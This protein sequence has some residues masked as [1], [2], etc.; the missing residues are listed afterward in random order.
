MEHDH[1]TY[2]MSFEDAQDYIS[3]RGLDIPLNDGDVFND[4]RDLTR[5]IGNVLKWADEHQIRRPLE[6]VKKAADNSFRNGLCKCYDLTPMSH[7]MF[8]QGVLFQRTGEIPEVNY[9]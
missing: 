3:K 2:E 9:S 5:T 6:D 4:D 1:K 8:I 7:H